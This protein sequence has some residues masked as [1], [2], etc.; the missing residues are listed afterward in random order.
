VPATG[1]VGYLLPSSSDL[2]FLGLLL[3]LSAGVLVPRLLGDGG[4]GWHI[5]N[6]EQMLRAHAVT[7]TDSF[8]ATMSGQTWYA[9]EWLY[10]LLIAGI[11]QRTGLNGV[12]LFTTLVIAGTFALTLRFTLSR[13][14]HLPITV[15]LLALAMAASAIHLLARPHVL[16]WLLA[17][18]W[19]HLLDCWDAGAGPAAGGRIHDRRLF[20]LPVL[21]LFWVNLHGGFVTGFLLLGLY[22]AAG[23]IRYAAAA[24]TARRQTARKR[25][26]HLG[27]VAG[28]SLLASLLNPYSY[29][30]HRHIYRYL[31]N[32]FLMD[33]I[34]EFRSPNFHGAAEQCF[35]VLLLITMAAL[36]VPREKSRVSHLLVALF[37]AASGLY[38]ARNLPLSSLLLVM[39]V[40][41]RLSKAVIAVGASPELAGWLRRSISRGAAF[42]TR[43][44][45]M[46]ASLHGHLWPLAAVALE[47]WICTH[48]GRLASLQLAD[49]HFDARRF[50][51]AA[52]E[53]LVQRGIREPV[54]CPDSWGGYLIYRLYPQVQVFVDDRHDLYGEQYLKNYLKVVRAEPGWDE[55][56]DGQRVRIVLAPEQSALASIL[57]ERRQWEI[58]YQDEVAIVFE[59]GQTRARPS[60]GPL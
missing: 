9:W 24:E 30:L 16:S 28:L 54:F 57:K 17:V 41:P 40:A 58:L 45:N 26:Q 5:R 48:G 53:Q 8:S 15:V 14:G 21:M 13:G 47:L 10:D 32:R 43:M 4:I 36:A 55:V 23:V 7:R 56:L 59:R 18:L 1:W 60:D 22:F 37:A 52:A 38:A 50:P 46:E 11:H 12:V 35:A 51:V 20:W 49:A 31:S 27:V 44:G 3:T 6:G 39:I 2:I 29:A 19:F 34:E 42:A 25:L 33:H